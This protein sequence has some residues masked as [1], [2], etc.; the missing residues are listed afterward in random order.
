MARLNWNSV[1]GG[2]GALPREAWDPEAAPAR[3]D[4]TVV[5]VIA[6]VGRTS[7]TE[8]ERVRR[9]AAELKATL[10]MNDEATA[11]RRQRQLRNARVV[12]STLKPR[13][14]LARSRFLL[15][16]ILRAS[17]WNAGKRGPCPIDSELLA[18]EANGL[19]AL[20][21]G[22][23]PHE[24]L[25]EAADNLRRVLEMARELAPTRRAAT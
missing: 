11:Q 24:K 5:R 13:Q 17:H 8:A 19:A 20:C 18:A 10:D 6:S 14:V 3:R 12:D 25:M 22:C 9:L 1:S 4:D 2:R 7:E 15:N 16:E 21:R 23:A